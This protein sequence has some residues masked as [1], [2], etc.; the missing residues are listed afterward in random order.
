ME[1]NSNCLK[2]KYLTNKCLEISNENERKIIQSYINS[3][4]NYCNNNILNK[5]CNNYLTDK[6]YNNFNKELKSKLNNLCSLPNTQCRSLCKYNFNQSF[7]YKYLFII[8]IVIISIIFSIFN[9]IILNDK[10]TF[11][12]KFKIEKIIKYIYNK[13]FYKIIIKI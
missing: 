1:K 9:N 4:N 3:N 10:K 12:F 7:C 8:F 13:T 6:Y 11:Q 2:N 5:E